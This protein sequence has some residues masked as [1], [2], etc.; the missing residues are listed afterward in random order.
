MRA[1][2][3]RSATYLTRRA[4]EQGK[5]F[6]APPL[7]HR[8]ST[9]LA[10]RRCVQ[11][12]LHWRRAVLLVGP[13]AM[14]GSPLCHFQPCCF[15]SAALKS[16][17]HRRQKHRASRGNTG[18][19]RTRSDPTPPPP[20]YEEAYRQTDITGTEFACMQNGATILL[21]HCRDDKGSAGISPIDRPD[22][23]HPEARLI[24]ILNATQ[25]CRTKRK[26]V[27]TCT[28]SSTLLTSASQADLA[29]QRALL[30][31]IVLLGP[32]PLRPAGTVRHAPA[33]SAL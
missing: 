4:Q 7:G 26:R 22:Q 19:C 28:A 27:G 8:Q 14:R 12:R 2:R 23:G 13:H 15:A 21:P 16:N 1:E 17:A 9:A 20:F 18:H 25:S 6:L 11:R 3:V 10:W 5:F 30:H 33:V 29:T 24:Q 31:D 32:P